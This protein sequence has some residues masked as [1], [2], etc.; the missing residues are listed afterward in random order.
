M[1]PTLDEALDGLFGTRQ[2]Q[3]GTTQAGGAQTAAAAVQT[4]PGQPDSGA[5]RRLFEDAQK[6]MQQGDWTQFGKAMAALKQVLASP[7][8]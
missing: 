6:A 7:Q 2:P 3:G 8:K 4:A 5:A 1:E